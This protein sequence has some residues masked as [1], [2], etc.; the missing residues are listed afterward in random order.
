MPRSRGNGGVVGKVVTPG[1]SGAVSAQEATQFVLSGQWPGS[2]YAAAI[3]SSNQPTITSIIVTDSSYNNSNANTVSISNSFIKIIGTGFAN[4]ANVF[5]GGTQ[6]PQA[7]VTFT[8]STELRIRLPILT[9]NTNNT[10]SLFNTNGSGALSAS[11]LLSKAMV[12]DYLVVAGGGGGGSL[13]GGGGAGGLLTGNVVNLSETTYTITVGSGGSGAVDHPVRGTNGN[14]SSIVGVISTLG[15]GAGGSWSLSAGQSGGSG[16]GAAGATTSHVG[17]SGTEGPPRQGF[18]GGDAS[19]SSVAGGG[20][21]GAAALNTTSGSG[22][23]GIGIQNS[24]TGTSI[25]YAGGGGAGAWQGAYAAGSGGLGGGATSTAWNGAQSGTN[26]TG[27]GGSGGGFNGSSSFAPGGSGGSGVVIIRYDDTYPEALTTGSPTVT[28]SGG[29]RIYKF[30]SSG[31]IT[32][33]AQ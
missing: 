4:G 28:T 16:G 14:T 18:A 5:I 27:G 17:G 3:V 20:G 33:P 7:N 19:G 15:G 32:L 24:I 9:N 22:S 21:A 1:T 30:T 31:T 23:G 8:S 2:T 26:N 11:R 25:Y 10:I 13:G 29:Y 6:V 12:F